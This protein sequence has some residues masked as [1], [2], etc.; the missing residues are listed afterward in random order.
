MFGPAD[1]TLLVLGL[2]TVVFTAAA[3]Y[4]DGQI[5]LLWDEPIQRFVE[6]HRNDQLTNVLE[7]LTLLGHQNA[8]IPATAAFIAIA[9]SRCRIL[10]FLLVGLTVA[11]IVIHLALKDGVTRDRPGLDPLVE[12]VGN[13]YPS[14][15]VISAVL[16]WGLAPFIVG[17][18][19]W[20]RS[21]WYLVAALAGLVMLSSTISRFYLGVHWASDS[22]VG[23]IIGLFLLIAT[24][25][26]IDRQHDGQPVLPGR[27]GRALARWAPPSSC[28]MG[29][30]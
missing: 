20:R 23:L 22:L 30:G 14:G 15:H 27:L 2:A 3:A 12:A 26:M 16:I 24:H 9:W 25:V 18:L 1:R 11:R 28:R 6:S 29:T 5:L 21:L 13:S 17:L 7:L 19:T 4:N 10:S 8:I